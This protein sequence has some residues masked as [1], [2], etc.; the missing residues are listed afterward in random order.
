MGLLTPIRKDPVPRWW[1]G[2]HRGKSR[3]LWPSTTKQF[4]F[5][6]LWRLR[7]ASRCCG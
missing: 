7:H 6:L 1:Q 3:L 5:S 4:L 2:T